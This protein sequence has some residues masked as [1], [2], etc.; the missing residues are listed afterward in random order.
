MRDT[1]TEIEPL[2]NIIRHW[3]ISKLSW[4]TE[5]GGRETGL[6]EATRV[7]GAR[8][9]AGSSVAVVRLWM[10]EEAAPLDRCTERAATSATLCV[11]KHYG[12]NPSRVS[13]ALFFFFTFLSFH[14]IFFF[15]LSF[16]MECYLCI[17]FT[18]NDDAVVFFYILLWRMYAER[19]WENQSL[20]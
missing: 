3:L 8:R 16:L 1:H 6:A 20:E 18:H 4:K 14:F 10:H 15:F 9:R 5:G 12:L 7:S 13:P 17:L 2:S 11:C 19:R